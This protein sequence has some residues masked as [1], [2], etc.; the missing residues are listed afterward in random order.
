VVPTEH[1]EE[2]LQAREMA[3]K[4]ICQEVQDD[5]SPCQDWRDL[6]AIQEPLGLLQDVLQEK[7][8]SNSRSEQ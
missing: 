3:V 6:E 4:A 1:R 2:A 8:K 5:V 7:A